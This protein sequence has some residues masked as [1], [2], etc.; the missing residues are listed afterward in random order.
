[1]Q[2]TSAQLPILLIEDS[3]EDYTALKRAWQQTGRSN[4]I[5]W[6]RDGDEALALLRECE[7]ETENAFCPSLIL[8]DLNLPGTEGREVLETIKRDDRL[9]AIPVIV[10]TTS[11][12]PRDVIDCYQ[13]GANGYQ[14]KSA[15]YEAFKL[16]IQRT[17]DYWLGTALI[18]TLAE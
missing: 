9:R 7:P 14:L 18:P 2:T 10:M 15:N 12:N 5:H 13:R 11:S 4:P 16:D 8:L 17:A 1:M 6:C 3:N